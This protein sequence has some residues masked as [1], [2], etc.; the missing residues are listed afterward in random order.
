MNTK[1]W[2]MSVCILVLATSAIRAEE[3]KPE[4]PY[5]SAKV[6]DW[7]E[8]KI[9]NEK[10]GRTFSS[11]F[12]FFVKEKYENEIVFLRDE[13]YD[14]R[15]M[16]QGEEKY[17]LS[18]PYRQE[19]DGESWHYEIKAEKEEKVTVGGKEYACKMKE[20]TITGSA[21]D[22]PPMTRK[23]WISK[24]VPLDGIVKSVT[25]VGKDVTT[26]E[27]LSCGKGAGK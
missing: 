26:R 27:L 21:P 14:G 20:L 25:H 12:K 10:S 2:C 24:D 8:Y 9:T 17:D 11:K 16:P 5:K 18:K 19:G 13:F 22:A 23:V 15:Q 3:K 7:I 1:R 4:H 6:G